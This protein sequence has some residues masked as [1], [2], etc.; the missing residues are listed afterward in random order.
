MP[1]AFRA[2]HKLQQ[3]TVTA[4]QEVRGNTEIRNPFVIRMRLRIKTVEEQVRNGVATEL[5]R[6]VAA[7]PRAATRLARRA[8]LDAFETPLAEGIRAEHAAF[9]ALASSD[10][11][12]TRLRSFLKR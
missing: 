5:A 2:R 8:V 3:R 1:G 9:R 4:N 12:N 11:R 10:E 6:R 7:H